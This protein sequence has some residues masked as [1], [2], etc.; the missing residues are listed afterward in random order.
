MDTR[1]YVITHKNVS[2]P[3]EEGYIPLQ[4]GAS[5]NEPLPYEGD[6]T[7]DNISDKNSSY[8]ELTGMYWIWKNVKCDNVGICHYRRYYSN[9][10]ATRILR[11]QEYEDILTKYDVITTRSYILLESAYANF[12]TYHKSAGLDICRNVIEE[13][14]HEYLE[15]F[16]KCMLDS[17]MTCCNMMITRKSLFDEYCEWLFSILF[18]VENKIRPETISD[19]Y[20]RRIMGFLGERLMRVWLMMQQ[21]RIKEIRMVQSD[22]SES[23]IM[24]GR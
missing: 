22:D 7:G 9:E 17:L 14:C 12:A 13:H 21:V 19:T 4:V 3:E 8:C 6:N 20:N 16:D 2:M 5:V 10:D 1:I 15:A 23:K 18:L 24:F 11:K